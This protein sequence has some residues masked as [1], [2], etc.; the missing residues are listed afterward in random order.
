[1]KRRVYTSGVWDIL[2]AS[3]INAMQKAMS[4]VGEGCELIVGV[5][6]DE[7]AMTYKRKPIQPYAERVAAIEAL[8]F[9]TGVVTAP[10]FPTS[11]FYK[12]HKLDVHI[13]D[14][15]DDSSG[16]DYYLEPKKLGIIQFIGR[17]PVSSTS[18][19]IRSIAA[20]TKLSK[21]GGMTNE[22]IL[23]E[24]ADVKYVYKF[25]DESVGN[26]TTLLQTLDRLS[27]CHIPTLNHYWDGTTLRLDYLEGDRLHRGHVDNIISG[28]FNLHKCGAVLPCDIF[29]IA[30][31]CGYLVD[32]IFSKVLEDDRDNYVPIHVDLIPENVIARN[33]EVTLIDWDYTCLGPKEIDYATMLFEGLVEVRDLQDRDPSFDLLRTQMYGRFILE[34]WM[35]WCDKKG[36][37]K[38]HEYRAELAA[39]SLKLEGLQDD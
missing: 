31:R 20:T 7:D 10:L 30:D 9:V 22:N 6:T 26:H 18:N 8:P 34:V 14:K 2:H 28:V 36:Y 17:D 27:T 32:S 1:M 15:D 13:Q 39:K 3:H 37:D 16:L 24:V 19:I 5:S 25:L 23:V 38:S 4:H 33:K 12:L 29:D 11:Q 21:L 35:S